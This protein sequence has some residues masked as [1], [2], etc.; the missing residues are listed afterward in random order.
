MVHTSAVTV[1][2]CIYQLLE[3]L[4]RLVLFQTPLVYLI[5]QMVKRMSLKQRVEPRTRW[6]V[7]LPN[8]VNH[9]G[10]YTRRS[11]I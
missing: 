8:I 10:Y 7:T 11:C 1:I 4:P 3:V 9:Y 5:T 6:N 2:N